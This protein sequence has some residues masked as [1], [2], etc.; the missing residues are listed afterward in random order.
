MK[1]NKRQVGWIYA[2]YLKKKLKEI[3][4]A[5]TKQEVDKI[6]ETINV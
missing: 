1:D 6:L 4:Q 5:T 3:K 2:N